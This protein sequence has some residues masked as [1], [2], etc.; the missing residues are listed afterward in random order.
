MEYPFYDGDEPET[1]ETNPI[2]FY[3]AIGIGLAIVSI[4]ALVW[5]CL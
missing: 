4:I 2:L 1:D 3:M 5:L